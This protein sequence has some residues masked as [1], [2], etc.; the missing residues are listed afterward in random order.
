M[1]ALTSQFQNGGHDVRSRSKVL[2]CQQLSE[3]KHLPRE[4]A[5]TP[6]SS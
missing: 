2:C 3:T 4:Y 5:A 6:I 1:F